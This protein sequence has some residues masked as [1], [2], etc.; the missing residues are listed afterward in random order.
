MKRKK[1]RNKIDIEHDRNFK[2]DNKIERPLYKDGK[3]KTDEK[4]KDR[5]KQIYNR[6]ESLRQKDRSQI[7]RKFKIDEQKERQKTKPRA[8][9]ELFIFSFL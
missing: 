1:D 9:W 4:K 6:I 3:F 7:H 8:T 5:N 2:I